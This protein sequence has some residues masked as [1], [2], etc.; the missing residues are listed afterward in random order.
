M[1]YAWKTKAE[2]D[3]LCVATQHLLSNCEKDLFGCIMA[4]SGYATYDQGLHFLSVFHGLSQAD[5]ELLRK[6]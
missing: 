5:E 1:L 3:F 2:F 6:M 4:T